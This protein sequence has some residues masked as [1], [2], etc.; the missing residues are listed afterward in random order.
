M[1][2]NRAVAAIAVVTACALLYG[3]STTP[4]LTSGEG[5]HAIV[6]ENHREENVSATVV[7]AHQGTTMGRETLTVPAHSEALVAG[8]SA[9]PLHIGPRRVTVT[10]ADSSGASDSVLLHIDD[11]YRDVSFRFRSQGQLDGGYGVC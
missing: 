11:C 4:T 9:N 1:N 3:A 7:V 5:E 6:V 10:V 2:R 8:V